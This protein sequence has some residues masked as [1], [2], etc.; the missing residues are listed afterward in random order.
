MVITIP[1]IFL[2]RL[3][4]HYKLNQYERELYVLGKNGIPGVNH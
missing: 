2:K 1:N 4:E 3:I